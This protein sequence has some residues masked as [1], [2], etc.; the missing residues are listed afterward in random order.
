MP[1]SKATTS[2]GR[3]QHHD[4][5]RAIHAIEAAGVPASRKSKGLCV[6]YK[7]HHYP[8]KLLLSEASNGALA[9]GDFSGGPQSNDRL[10][11]LGFTVVDCNCGGTAANVADHAVSPRRSSDRASPPTR[12]R[13]WRSSRPTM[14]VAS[15]YATQEGFKKPPRTLPRSSA[16]A[17]SLRAGNQ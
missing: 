16:S 7:G 11:Q 5:L 6:K 1:L 13:G 15:D 2:L 12:V 17:C 3:I 4:V 10:K 9:S 14:L 8:P